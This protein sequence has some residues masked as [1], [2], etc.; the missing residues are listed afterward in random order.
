[1]TEQGR[2]GNLSFWV[3]KIKGLGPFMCPGR[4]SEVI[5]SAP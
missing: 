1:M 5:P 4:N 3:Q 2:E